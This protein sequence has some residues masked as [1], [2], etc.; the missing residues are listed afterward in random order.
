MKRRRS[1]I[2]RAMHISRFAKLYVAKIPFDLGRCRAYSLDPEAGAA[3][4]DDD[5]VITMRMPECR[6]A[7]R[8]RHIPDT[9]EFI[10][11]FR[12][13]PWLAADFHGRLSAAVPSRPNLL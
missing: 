6:V 10:F 12:V 3:Q 2:H 8:H 13:M 11:K 1:H 9:H 7:G 5:I 4:R